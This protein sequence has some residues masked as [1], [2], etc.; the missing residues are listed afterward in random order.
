MVEVVITFYPYITDKD[1]EMQ[2]MDTELCVHR[3]VP[4]ESDSPGF[5]YI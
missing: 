2:L 4:D 5:E 1:N 3:D